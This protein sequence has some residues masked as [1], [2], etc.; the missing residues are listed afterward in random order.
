MLCTRPFADDTL[1]QVLS[2]LPTPLLTS[3]EVKA[4]ILDL[5][6]RYHRYRMNSVRRARNE[7]RHCVWSWVSLSSWI[8]NSWDFRSILRLI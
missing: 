2:L 4:R 7:W 5:G 8:H 6:A 1:A 3:E